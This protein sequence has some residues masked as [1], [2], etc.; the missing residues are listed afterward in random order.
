MRA[1]R[2]SSRCGAAGTQR[3]PIRAAWCVAAAASAVHHELTFAH[4]PAQCSVRSAAMPFGKNKKL[5][6]PRAKKTKVEMVETAHDDSNDTGVTGAAVRSA[7]P[8]AT[9]PAPP[10]PGA[11]LREEAEQELFDACEEWGAKRR[12]LKRARERLSVEYRLFSI[13]VDRISKGEKRTK[14]PCGVMVMDRGYKAHIA[15]LEAQL[16][17]ARASDSAGEARAWVNSCNVRVHE[18]EIAKLRRVIRKHHVRM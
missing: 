15:L 8:G 10:S 7:P 17:E 5:S 9:A 16:A 6:M 2:P 11:A 18:L 4:R 12:A 14:K 13:K 1:E 3:C